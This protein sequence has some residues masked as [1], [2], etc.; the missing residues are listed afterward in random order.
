MSAAT[1]TP[2]RFT[3]TQ[4]PARHTVKVHA[5]ARAGHGTVIRPR[6]VPFIFRAD[7]AQCQLACRGQTAA[8]QAVLV[9]ETVGPAVDRVA[10]SEARV[11][12]AGVARRQAGRPSTDRSGPHHAESAVPAGAHPHWRHAAHLGSRPA[13]NALA[14]VRDG[15]GGRVRL[16]RHCPGPAARSPLRTVAAPIPAPTPMNP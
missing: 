4:P 7:H 1:E 12:G 13:S 5:G 16:A 11:A 15:R 2:A 8:M 6:H 10:N 14:P 9:D 3:S